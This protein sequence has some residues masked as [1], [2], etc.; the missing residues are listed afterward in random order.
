MSSNRL[1]E[2]EVKILDAK[3]PQAYLRAWHPGGTYFF[4]V[5]L[6]Q[7]QGNSLLAEHIDLRR[8]TVRAVRRQP[9]EI[10]A[11]VVLPDHL[12][13][14]ME[15]PR[16][17]ADFAVRWRLIKAGFSK[18]LP[19]TEW[20]SAVSS[21]GHYLLFT[22]SRKM[23]SI[24]RIG[25]AGMREPYT[26]TIDIWRTSAQFGAM[27]CAYCALRRQTPGTG[28]GPELTGTVFA[29]SHTVNCSRDDSLAAKLNMKSS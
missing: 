26:T 27:R 8:E 20:R 13:C 24:R 7:R 3:I 9:F 6:L 18:G 14:V 2:S 4:T 21:I 23:D 11:W 19:K 12:H 25:V 10:H 29:R 22:G 5:N 16:G 17:D 28:Q 15:L 1:S